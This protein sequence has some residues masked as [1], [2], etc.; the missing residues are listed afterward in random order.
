[1]AS[2]EWRVG[3]DPDFALR[4]FLFACRAA[5]R[6]AVLRR[7][8]GSCGGPKPDPIPN[9]AVKPFSANGTKSQGLGE[10]VAARPAN[11]SNTRDLFS[12][13]M[14]AKAT[15]TIAGWSSPVARQA[16]NLKV[17]GSNPIPA[18]IVNCAPAVSLRGRFCAKA[19]IPASAP[20]SSITKSP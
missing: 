16:H 8:G 2:S 9:S 15:R 18:T 6:Q 17:I 10:S 3:S 12:S 20:T 14:S 5:A 13:L 4:R 7:P 19:R 1:M 11:H